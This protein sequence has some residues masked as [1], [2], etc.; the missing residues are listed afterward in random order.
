MATTLALRAQQARLEYD[1]SNRT[2]RDLERYFGKCAKLAF[3]AWVEHLNAGRPAGQRLSLLPGTL[4]AIQLMGESLT[5]YLSC[6]VDEDH[7][8][9]TFAAIVWEKGVQTAHEKVESVRNLA[10]HLGLA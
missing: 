3:E 4:S 6:P 7:H 1:R 10:R 8:H 2:G 9:E 5:A